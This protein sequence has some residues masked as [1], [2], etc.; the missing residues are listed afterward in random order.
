MLDEG[1]D[2]RQALT[3]LEVAELEGALAA[4]SLRISLHQVQGGAHQGRRVYLV[5]DQEVRLGD[6]GA[7][8]CKRINIRDVS[9]RLNTRRTNEKEP[10]GSF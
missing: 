8:P 3:S 6:N 4:H 2:F 10:E 9:F 7:A 5:D 1:Q